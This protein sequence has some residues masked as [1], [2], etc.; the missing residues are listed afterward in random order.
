MRLKRGV[1]HEKNLSDW[2]FECK[3]QAKRRDVTVRARPEVTLADPAFVQMLADLGAQAAV[4][5]ASGAASG[6]RCS[7]RAPRPDRRRDSIAP[8]VTGRT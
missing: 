1:T 4:S 3:D 5:I 6:S 8:T 2:F 7:G